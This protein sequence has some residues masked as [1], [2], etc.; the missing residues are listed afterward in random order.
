MFTYNSGY[1]LRIFLANSEKDGA[2]EEVRK[3]AEKKKGIEVYP[4]VGNS[5][6]VEITGDT[7]LPIS[8]WKNLM[9][10]VKKVVNNFNGRRQV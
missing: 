7:S 6:V 10:E 2:A 8:E 3:W 1:F 5:S 4:A 9:A